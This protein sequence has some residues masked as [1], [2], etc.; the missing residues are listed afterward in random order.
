MA[1]DLLTDKKNYISRVNRLMLSLMDSPAQLQ[2]TVPPLSELERDPEVQ[3]I[4]Q[5]LEDSSAE[6]EPKQFNEEIVID[7]KGNP[8]VQ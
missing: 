3:S 8:K 6:E 7:E 2:E 4:L 1:A 5:E